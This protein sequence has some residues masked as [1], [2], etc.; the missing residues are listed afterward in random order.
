MHN[1]KLDNAAND[2]T[3]WLLA[4][5][6]DQQ[7]HTPPLKC[8]SLHDLHTDTFHAL[9]DLQKLHGLHDLQALYDLHAFHDLHHMLL[10]ALCLGRTSIWIDVLCIGSAGSWMKIA[11]G[12]ILES[13]AVAL[14]TGQQ[15][16]E[17]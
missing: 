8:P 13:S 9:H 12:A 14:H 16:E 7:D 15:T 4:T 6:V 3:S 10:T 5:P 11:S 1:E 2:S 17:V